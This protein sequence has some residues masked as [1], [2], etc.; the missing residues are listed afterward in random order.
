[1]EN[2]SLLLQ[3]CFISP[4]S[5]F[6]NKRKLPYKQYHATLVDNGG[7]TDAIPTG[8]RLA[9]QSCTILEAL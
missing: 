6:G 9:I 8:D 4:G 2:A 1:M 7:E 5:F 3:S